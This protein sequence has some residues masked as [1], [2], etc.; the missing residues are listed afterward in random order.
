M[1]ILTHRTH[2][3][4]KN[5][6]FVCTVA[7]MLSALQYIELFLSLQRHNHE[8]PCKLAFHGVNLNTVTETMKPV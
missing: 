3:F 5:G 7:V 8:K 1:I 2:R 6:V 4:D